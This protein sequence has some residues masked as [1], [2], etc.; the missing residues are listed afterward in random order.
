MNKINVFT[1]R[2]GTGCPDAKKV[3]K[4]GAAMELVRGRG[5]SE[6]PGTWNPGKKAKE[7]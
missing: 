6:S 3:A 1:S 7:R 5:M 4:G 2:S